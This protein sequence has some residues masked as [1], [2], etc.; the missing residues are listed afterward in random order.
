MANLRTLDE[1]SRIAGIGRRTL[2]RLVADRKLRAYKL[3]GDRRHY[4]DM[5]EL[6]RLRRPKPVARPKRS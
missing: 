1:A 5:D 2:D 6:D 3:V 4:V